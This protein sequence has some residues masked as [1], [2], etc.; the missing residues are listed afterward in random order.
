MNRTSYTICRAP[1]KVKVW[2]A[3]FNNSAFQDGSS[4]A[5]NQVW[6]LPSTEPSMTALYAC[7]LGNP[8]YLFHPWAN[9]GYKVQLC[10][11]NLRSTHCAELLRVRTWGQSY[12]TRRRCGLEKMRPQNL[13]SLSL[14]FDASAG[15]PIVLGSLIHPFTYQASIHQPLY[16]RRCPE[17]WGTE[18]KDIRSMGFTCKDKGNAWWQDIL[19]KAMIRLD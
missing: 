16:P 5:L 12:W 2:G 8:F 9:W 19:V 15:A 17:W 11:E 1:C 13:G 18:D 4:R 10:L 7:A 6:I 3:L 14:G